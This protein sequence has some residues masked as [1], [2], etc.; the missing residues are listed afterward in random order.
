LRL[1]RRHKPRHRA[2][3]HGLRHAELSLPHMAAYAGRANHHEIAAGLVLQACGDRSRTPFCIRS[4][5]PIATCGPETVAGR[6]RD[7]AD[8]LSFAL[9]SL[10]ENA[11]PY[12]PAHVESTG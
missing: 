9:F 4:L 2:R 5:W 7:K 1:P 12:N 8:S 10:R 3:R 6:F 11:A